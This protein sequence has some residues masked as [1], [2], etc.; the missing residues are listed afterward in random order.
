MLDTTTIIRPVGK[1]HD[2]S[3]EYAYQNCHTLVSKLLHRP[4]LFINVTT[5]GSTIVPLNSFDFRHCMR[6]RSIHTN[7]EM[8]NRVWYHS[9][10]TTVHCNTNSTFASTLLNMVCHTATQRY[11]E[12]LQFLWISEKSWW[13]E[14]RK[15]STCWGNNCTCKSSIGSLQVSS[16]S[17]ACIPFTSSKNTRAEPQISSLLVVWL[18]KLVIWAMNTSTKACEAGWHNYKSSARCH[19]GTLFI[20]LRHGLWYECMHFALR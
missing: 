2:S 19:Q 3:A 9:D 16:V 1:F 15:L 17:Q 14:N 4:W 18:P 8:L 6:G 11:S 20:S 13:C 12:I 10:P 7:L 5:C